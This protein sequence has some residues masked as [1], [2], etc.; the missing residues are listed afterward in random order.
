MNETA[1]LTLRPEPIPAFAGGLPA[2]LR[3]QMTKAVKA[4]MLRTPSQHTRRAYQ[5]DLDQFLAHVGIEAG[6]WEQLV[7]IRPED[8]AAWRDT[9]AA[10]EQTNSTI[11]RKLTALRSLFSYL[12]TYGYTGANPAH[13]DFVSAPAVSRDGKTVGLSPFDCRRLLDAPKIEDLNIKDEGKRLI[14]VGIR[15]RAMF[16]VLAYSGCRVGELVKLRVRDYRTN[17][18][19]RVLNIT[20]KGNKERTTPMHLEAVERLAEW[21]AIPGIGDNPAAPLFRPQRSARNHGKDGFR[22][23]AMTTRA[24]E[25]LIERYVKAL[26]LDVNVTVHSLR[27]TALT[28][29]RER[30]SDIIDLQDFAGHAD[31]RTTLTYIRSRDRLSKSPAYVL[32]Y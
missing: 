26:N 20:G 18:E 23:K 9:L 6:A 11:R 21:L 3:E 27:V 32:K 17:G 25:K 7:C 19:H 31:P 30:G 2:D 24:V 4:W 22:P 1:P 8:V 5:S 29:A 10:D 12:K 15:D 16:A 28:T 13:S 14:P